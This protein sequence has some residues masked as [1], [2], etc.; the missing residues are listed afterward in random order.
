M[1]NRNKKVF[2]DFDW[3]L[4]ITS[5]VLCAIGLIS[6]RSSTYNANPGIQPL[7][8]QI[9][10]TILGFVVI[11]I[12]QYVDVDYLK[13]IA[14]PIYLIVLFFLLATLIFGFGAE[15]W[16]ANSWLKIGPVTFQPSEFAKFGVIIFLATILDEY[17]TKI[18]KPLT[19]LILAI[20][21]G[22]PILLILRQPD[23]GTAAVLV[24]FVAAMIFYAGISWKYIALAAILALL[25]IP[26]IYTQLSDMQKLRILN[27]IDPAR[28]PR[29]SNYQSLQGII[30]IGSGKLTGHGFLKGTQTQYGFI[31]EQETDYIFTA[32]V[33][34]FGFIGGAILIISYAILL[35]RMVLIAYKAK[36]SFQ[37]LL[38]IGIAAMIFVHI[39]ENIGMTMGLMPVTGIPLPLISKGGTF[40]ILNLMSI[41]LVLS[42]GCQRKELEFSQE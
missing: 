31:P 6:I 40:Q 23:L 41:G 35:V 26:I 19:I 7:L 3:V 24:F 20:S 11:L 38:V 1:F 15:Q 28:D 25:A 2:A 18:N 36:S 30:A 17:K 39:F 14:K 29:G 4:L 32:L 5:V 27:F 21:M 10:A 13:K 12:M 33:E 34:E 22:I 42:V 9:V 16:G 37:S 8:S